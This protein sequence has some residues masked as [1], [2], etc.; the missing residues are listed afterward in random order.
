M[1]LTRDVGQG[2]G[3]PGAEPPSDRI[4]T[5][6]GLRTIT[7]ARWEGKPY[8]YVFLNGEPV[9]L[10][11]VLD[12]AFH[13]EGIY[14]YPSDDV[15]RADVQAKDLGLNMLRCHI[16][17]NDPRYYYWADR[18]GM[19]V[20]YDLPSASIYT[21]NGPTGSTFR[22]A[23]ARD[24]SHPCI[25]AWILFNETW[26]LEEHQRPEGVV[27]GQGDVLP[28]QV[29]RSDSTGGRR[30]YL[31]DHVTTDIQHLALLHRRL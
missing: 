28:D 26:G 8:E 3:A 13:P 10:R 12:Q 7:T 18:L 9:F 4:S 14:A 30:S 21:P 15:I 6:F 11:G 22:D 24:Y 19:L 25:F 2:E 31:Y 17:I 20:M 5:Y 1:T 27:M 16:K 23:L 29:P